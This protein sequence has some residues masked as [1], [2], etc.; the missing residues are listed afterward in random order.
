M[1]K[2][3]LSIPLVVIISVILIGTIWYF[4]YQYFFDKNSRRK[5]PI[6]AEVNQIIKSNSEKGIIKKDD[7]NF[8]GINEPFNN[9]SK[10]GLTTVKKDDKPNPRVA[11]VSTTK[12]LKVYVQ[13]QNVG[14]KLSINTYSFSNKKELNSI[15]DKLKPNDIVYLKLNGKIYKVTSK[16]KDEIKSLI[17]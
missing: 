10:G 6:V 5:E 9:R 12:D 8:F 1:N 16:N 11:G 17:K 13:E 15:L 2:Q 14:K 3:K 4:L 7:N